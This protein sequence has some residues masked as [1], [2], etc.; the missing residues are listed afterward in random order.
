MEQVADLI[1]KTIV[2]NY[3][4]YGM[5]IWKPVNIKEAISKISEDIA[6]SL[7]YSN[8]I[9][10]AES[11]AARLNV[12]ITP[13]IVKH[14]FPLYIEP[15]IV[16]NFIYKVDGNE[17]LIVTYIENLAPDNNRFLETITEYARK[18]RSSFILLTDRTQGYKQL[19]KHR[20][21][22]F[23][24]LYDRTI[25]F[26]DNIFIKDACPDLFD[27]VPTGTVGMV[28]DKKN[29][30]LKDRPTAKIFLIK[31]EAFQKFHFISPSIDEAA[32]YE[33]EIMD[34]NYDDSVIVC[35]KEHSL[36]WKPFGF[37]YRFKKN[38]NKAWIEITA[39]RNGYEIF[40]LPD[41]YNFSI[42]SNNKDVVKENIHIVRYESF[43][44]D[45]CVINTWI[46]DNN[47]I[48]YKD[49]VPIDMMD[50]KVLLLYHQE[51][52][53]QSIET[54][55]YL[56]LIDLNNLGSK[57]DNSYTESRIYYEDFEYLF[58]ANIKYCGLTTGS[59]NL[60]YVGLNPI[61]KLHN[62]NGIRKLDEKVILCS[63]IEP[64][65]R[66]FSDKKTVLHNVFNEIT[67]DLIVEFLELIN[68]SPPFENKY[69]AVSN[70]IIAKRDILKS[71]FDFYQQ[72]EIL[73]K[74]DFFMRKHSLTIKNSVYGK[75]TFKRRS[76]FFAETATS[77]W[78]N[79]NC[80]TLMP[81]EV[82]RYNWYK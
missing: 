39:Y 63:D 1:I 40:D 79:K 37:P 16:D 65:E 55:G 3:N 75:D 2:D 59:W 35:D 45:D 48:G 51:K 23:V 73:H 47:I 31:A 50:F 61:D 52:Q 62:W 70:Q 67:I 74:I 43:L 76:G 71:L 42:L 25:F 17:R 56:E 9:S 33:N 80:F 81:Q 34:S 6:N 54:K 38:E 24:N 12:D 64:V 41:V 46:Y 27:I 58:P 82:L 11:V 4:A 7:D 30:T 15:N 49:K 60:K 20:V 28:N 22:K 26:G 69:V 53:R 10:C 77:L 78:I 66:F 8:A 29:E 21:E 57:F 13:F 19:E 68:L 14:K 72:N 5:P 32:T 18:T 36:I 44:K